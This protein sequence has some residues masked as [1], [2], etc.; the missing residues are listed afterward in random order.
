MIFAARD[1]DEVG[2][3]AAKRE[4]HEDYRRHYCR[5]LRVCRKRWKVS[6]LNTADSTKSA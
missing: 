2:N 1:D 4:Q 6:V 5:A 3:D